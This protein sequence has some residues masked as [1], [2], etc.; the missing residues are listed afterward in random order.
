MRRG[1][2]VA[3]RV[4]SIPTPARGRT[5]T[6]VDD[7]VFDRLFTELTESNDEGSVIAK[8]GE[9]LGA[10][11]SGQFIDVGPSGVVGRLNLVGR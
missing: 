10:S 5:V 11:I 7:E 1:F 8:A 6:V 2:R 3:A 4:P 9:P